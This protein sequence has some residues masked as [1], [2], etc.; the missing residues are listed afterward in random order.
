MILDLKLSLEEHLKYILTK[1]NKITGLLRK[2][3]RR[4]YFELSKICWTE[5]YILRS[6]R[7]KVFCKKGVLKNFAKFTGKHLCQSPFFDKVAG[8]RKFWEIFKNTFSY[9]TPLVAASVFWGALKI[10]CRIMFQR[11]WPFL[12]LPTWNSISAF[13]VGPSPSKWICFD[14]SPLKWWKMLFISS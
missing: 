14:E 3:Q 4:W 7:P 12:R 6:R 11:C 1:E 8:L 2:L 10:N 5:F 13:K 9:R